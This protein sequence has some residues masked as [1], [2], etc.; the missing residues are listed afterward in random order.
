MK[1]APR[2]HE[3]SSMFKDRSGP[4]CPLF[5]GKADRWLI[6][7][8]LTTYQRGVCPGEADEEAISRSRRSISGETENCEWFSRKVSR[9]AAASWRGQMTQWNPP[10]YE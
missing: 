2:M 7:G 8:I 10:S 9:A 5:S 1:T 6:L 4:P 3:L